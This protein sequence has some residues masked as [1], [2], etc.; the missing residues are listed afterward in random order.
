VQR[1]VLQKAEGK[2]IMSP[3]ANSDYMP[4][5]VVERVFLFD[6]YKQLDYFLERNEKP[7]RQIREPQRR[8]IHVA[9]LAWSIAESKKDR[10]SAI[11]DKSEPQ[12][13]VSES[14]CRNLK[15]KFDVLSQELSASREKH[16]LLLTEHISLLNKYGEAGRTIQSLRKKL[17]AVRREQSLRP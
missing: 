9:D 3:K 17:D 6:N 13:E 2:E 14:S 12:I 5:K 4:A 15:R 7:V 11:Q 1:G 10:R 8:F 16:C